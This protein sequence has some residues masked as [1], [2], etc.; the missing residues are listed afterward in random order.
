MKEEITKVIDNKVIGKLIYIDNDNI[1]IVSVFVEQEYRGQGIAQELMEKII[2]IAKENN[3]QIIP[4]CS[5]A[6]KYME[7]HV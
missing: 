5:Y 2:K 6:K 7:K 4:I 3:K 1:S